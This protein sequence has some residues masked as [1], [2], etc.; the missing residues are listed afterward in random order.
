MTTKIIK[1]GKTLTFRCPVCGKDSVEEALLSMQTWELNEVPVDE[2]GNAD[3]DADAYACDAT[4]EDSRFRCAS[5]GEDIASGMDE[6][7]EYLEEHDGK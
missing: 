4:E 5:C 2:A 6:L 7:I 1:N 3:R